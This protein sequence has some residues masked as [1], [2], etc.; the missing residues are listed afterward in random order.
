MKTIHTKSWAEFER[1]IED[2]RSSYGTYRR[3]LPNG[4]V[5]ERR[6]NILFRGQAKAKWNLL[7]TLERKTEH[8]F[9]VLSYTRLALHARNELESFTGQR[10]VVP[11][12]PEL[13]KEIENNQDSCKMHLPAYDFMVY[14]RHHGYPSPLLDWTESPYIAAYFACLNSGNECPAIYCY[15]ER[16]DLVK[17]GSGGDPLISIRGPFVTTH[18]RHFAQ[19]AWYTISTQWDYKLSCHHFCNHE[20]VFNRDTKRQDILIKIILPPS[21]KKEALS[22][23]NDYNIN[24]F[25]LFQ[26]EDSLVKA[27]EIK[28]F[29]IEGTFS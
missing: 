19:K 15:I 29:D 28:H 12:F 24:H 3:E 13:E 4:N 9:D 17:G 10:W 27:M 7:T 11:T 5:F 1:A 6:I 21:F 16:P 22:K 18:K 2:V 25:T 20:K 26:S 8:R 14:L 23:L